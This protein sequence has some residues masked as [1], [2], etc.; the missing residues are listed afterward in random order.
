VSRLTTSLAE[1][2]AATVKSTIA[3]RES[4]GKLKRLWD[5]DA[6]LWTGE[7]ESKWRGWLDVVDQQLAP[8]DPLQ[9]FSQ[10]VQTQGFEHVLLLGMGGSSLC[11]EVLAMPFGRISR[12][13]ALHVLDS[14]DPAQVKASEQAIDLAK[15]RFIVSRKSGSTLEPN[16]SSSISS[17]APSRWLEL[18][19]WAATLWPSPIQARRCSRSERQCDLPPSAPHESPPSRKIRGK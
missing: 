11:P 4:G 6:S 14:T 13:P 2:L 12:R 7:D 3:E 18:T 15:T 17:S 19:R 5:R 8:H 10:D 1:S 9:Q 16:I